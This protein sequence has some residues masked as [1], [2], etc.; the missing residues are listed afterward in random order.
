MSAHLAD[1]TVTRAQPGTSEAQ[2]DML[3][4]TWMVVPP[5][6]T[7]DGYYSPEQSWKFPAHASPQVFHAPCL[8]DTAASG[9]QHHAMSGHF[10]LH[11]ATSPGLTQQAT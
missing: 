1:V 2:E 9:R 7:F 11:A 10:L 3:V 8:V 5:P 6:I 4:L